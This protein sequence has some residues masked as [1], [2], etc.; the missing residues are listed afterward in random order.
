MKKSGHRQVRWAVV[1]VVVVALT[2][3]TASAQFNQFQWTFGGDPGGEGFVTDQWMQVVSSSSG[4]CSGPLPGTSYFTTTA[5]IAGKVSAYLT[6]DNKDPCIS[7]W[8]FEKPVYI[9]NGQQFVIICDDTCFDFEAEFSFD[10]EAGDVFGLGAYSVDCACEPGV[11]D[12][13]NFKFEPTTWEDLGFSLAGTAGL[14]PSAQGFGK[15]GDNDAFQ[16][17]LE[18]ALPDANAFLVGSFSSLFA[19]FNGGVFVPNPAPPAVFLPLTVNP[20]GRFEL[21]GAWPPGVPAGQSLFLQVWV[22]DPGAPFGYSASNAL[23]A[24]TH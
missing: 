3:A 7:F 13:T 10:V 18:R 8:H 5:P 22:L 15:L 11:C 4:V 23:L 17:S 6:F 20:F 1:L 2:S 24:T 14:S 16:F 21:S 19:P 9:I 12:Y